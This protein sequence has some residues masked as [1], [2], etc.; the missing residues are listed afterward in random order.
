MFVIEVWTSRVPSAAMRSVGRPDSSSVI[1][2][3][4]AHVPSA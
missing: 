3:I 4:D 1:A 2:A